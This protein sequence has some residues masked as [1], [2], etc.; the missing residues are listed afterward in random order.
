MPDELTTNSPI[1]AA[2]RAATPGSAARAQ[3]ANELFP[4]GITHDSR[5]IEPYI[6]RENVYKNSRNYS[7]RLVFRRI[8]IFSEEATKCAVCCV[9]PFPLDYA[10]STATGGAQCPIPLVSCSVRSE[11]IVEL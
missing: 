2:Y 9:L 6:V 8:R 11:T 10:L 4:S 5:Y 1:I 7:D 3:R